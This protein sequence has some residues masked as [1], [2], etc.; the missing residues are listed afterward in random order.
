MKY[1]AVVGMLFFFL[2][3]FAQEETSYIELKNQG[4]EALRGNNFAEALEAYES[5]VAAWPEE[6]EMDAAMVFN[7]AT[8]ARRTKNSEKALE[9]YQQSVDLGYRPDFSTYYVASSLN[10]LGRDDEME[11]VLLKAIEEHKTSSVVG[12]MKKML[13][14]YY[15]KQGAEPFNRA[16]QVLASAANADPSQYEEITERANASFAEAKPWF[17]KVLEIDPGNENAQASLREVNSR[18]AE[19]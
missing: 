18:L 6:E 15:L 11:E 17:E 8:S 2:G 14:T 7:M 9:Y 5:A 16:A 10:A 12:H 1:L 4:N 3:S 13:T 19:N